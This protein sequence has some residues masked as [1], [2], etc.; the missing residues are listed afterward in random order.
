MQ[1]QH[2]PPRSSRDSPV[3]NSNYPPRD[4]PVR[5]N[6]NYAPTG[7]STFRGSQ[8]LATSSQSPSPV[9]QQQAPPPPPP[10]ACD[11]A[12]TDCYTNHG[13]IHS[14]GYPNTRPLSSGNLK[15][16]GTG[17]V[18]TM[19]CKKEVRFAEDCRDTCGTSSIDG[20]SDDGTTTSG[21]YIVE[22]GEVRGLNIETLSEINV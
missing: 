4:C 15:W 12:P 7:F 17:E 9:C 14:A 6:T 19:G 3:R 22:S 2:L 1:L 20:L 16:T 10:R 18:G 13:A 8:P 5:G 21:S 11:S